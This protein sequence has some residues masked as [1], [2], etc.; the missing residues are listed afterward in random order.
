MTNGKFWRMA[1]TMGVSIGFFTAGGVHAIEW[2]NIYYNS[3]TDI[4]LLHSGL[5]DTS[6]GSYI[7][8]G[9]TYNVDPQPV[10]V[11]GLWVL[12]V[13]P[14][15]LIQWSKVYGDR[16]DAAT[17]VA[18]PCTRGHVVAGYKVSPTGTKDA[19]VLKLD[20]RGEIEWEKTFA[21]MTGSYSY[22]P[23]AITVTHD[24]GYAVVGE[25]YE[26]ATGQR[27]A[28]LMRLDQNGNLL[29]HRGY[30]GVNKSDW[31]NTVKVTPDGGYIVGG[32]TCSF[33][34]AD[35][36]TGD[37]W[38]LKLDRDGQVEWEKTYGGLQDEDIKSLITT[39]DGYVVVGQTWSRGEGRGDGWIMKLD[40]QG[41]P[42]WQMSVGGREDDYFGSIV[43]TDG[44]FLLAGRTCSFSFASCNA[45]LA[46]VSDQGEVLWQ[47]AFDPDV[48]GA[49]DSAVAVDDPGDGGA[50][51]GGVSARY[52][53][54]VWG[55]VV[56]TDDQGDI[57][58]CPIVPTPETTRMSVDLPVQIS[59]G[60][61]GYLSD[62]Q[63][64]PAGL[65]PVEIGT[66]KEEACPYGERSNVRVAKVGSGGGTIVSEPQGILCG[67]DC[68]EVY[69]A[70]TTIILTALPDENSTFV[71]WSGGFCDGVT[72]PVCT[73]VLEAG[74]S[75]IQAIFDRLYTLQVQTTGTGFGTIMSDP[76][77]IAC[78]TDC[79][80][81]YS[82]G[83]AVRLT[84]RPFPG[85]V[86]SGW[87][88]DTDCNDGV[89]VMTSNKTCIAN[90]EKTVSASAGLKVISPNGGEIL[91]SGETHL[92]QWSS[93]SP[94]SKFKV[95]YSLDGGVTWRT[96]AKRA[97]GSSIS[98]IVPQVD[99]QF[100][101]CL[102]KVKRT[103]TKSS[104]WDISDAPF[105]IKP[106]P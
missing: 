97:S 11:E 69:P 66:P 47:R 18:Q 86:F 62:L 25:A 95:E 15:G 104:R 84:A 80:Q 100:D 65:T 28:W 52:D 82:Y 30:G 67:S 6:D 96:I 40:F 35:P 22:L 23:R 88:G 105:A 46:K 43:P 53:Q 54:T 9:E 41:N 102:V 49:W 106:A 37:G 44:G 103:D 4:S 16:G 55:W 56:R 98:W 58:G 63:V 70:G 91:A 83:E 38:V 34:M 14:T 24:C 81:G 31:F 8:V 7:A 33:G 79:R 19:W 3:N 26:V 93:S 76:A 85:S 94:G 74:V 60:A 99:R 39:S 77:G 68:E 32:R 59:N 29:W 36:W 45:W 12:K 21:D 48:S 90:F 92:I 78:G 75:I 73:G 51:I 2:A 61:L 1:L 13:F 89:V 42:V 64:A 87:S 5:R 57:R 20:S 72:E 50:I 10:S 101:Q 27:D 17:C 71:G